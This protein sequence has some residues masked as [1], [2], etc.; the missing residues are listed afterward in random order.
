MQ[1]F[2]HLTFVVVVVRVSKIY[3]SQITSIQYRLLHLNQP[4]ATL[5]FR[6]NDAFEKYGR[7]QE[8]LLMCQKES[9]RDE[10]HLHGIKTQMS[11]YYRCNPGK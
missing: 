2:S 7:I 6:Y 11:L 4:S 10:Q 5:I 8:M 9:A 1:H 3:L